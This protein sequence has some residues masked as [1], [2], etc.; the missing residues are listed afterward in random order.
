MGSQSSPQPSEKD[1]VLHN[2]VNLHSLE[3]GDVCSW[4]SYKDP[5]ITIG[6]A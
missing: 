4:G 2:V 5:L 3:I 6:H 1:W